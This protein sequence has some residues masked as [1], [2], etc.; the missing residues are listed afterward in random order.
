[1]EL[2]AESASLSRLSRFAPY[3]FDVVEKSSCL[4][5]VTLSDQN[6]DAHSTATAPWTRWAY[7]GLRERGA[8]GTNIARATSVHLSSFKPRQLRRPKEIPPQSTP[9]ACRALESVEHKKEQLELLF[10]AFMGKDAT[11]HRR[12]YTSG[13][14][15]RNTPNVGGNRK[16]Q[17]QSM[18]RSRC[19]LEHRGT[20]RC[21]R[22]SHR[23]RR[24][25]PRRRP[26][27]QL[28]TRVTGPSPLQY[29][30]STL[31]FSIRT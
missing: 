31:S 4:A 20:R 13:I 23:H 27:S 10:F 15:R 7:P 5:A 21:R 8:L 25:A 19:L 22:A 14:P 30:V 12:P 3:K 17:R 1:L 18:P 11:D 16:H 9:A 6:G 2:T 29:Q 28:L 24:G 26:E